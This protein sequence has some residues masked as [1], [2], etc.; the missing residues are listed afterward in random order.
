MSAA[1]G[2]LAAAALLISACGTSGARVTS[3]PIASI[4]GKPASFD[5]VEIDQG[6][7]RLYVADR[8]DQGVD[9]FD[10]SA[11]TAKFLKTIALKSSPN[12]LAIA[13]DLSR[14]Y[15]G[16]A[17]GSLA[18]VDINPVSP[19][20]YTVVQEVP[21]GGKSADLLDYGATRHEVYAG[22]GLDGTVTSIDAKTGTV[23]AH[24]TIGYAVEQPRFNPADG[25]LYVASPDADAMFQVNPNDG[26][27]KNKFGLGGCQPTGLAINPQSMVLIACRTSVLI[28]DLKTGNS[29]KFHQVT[30]GD[31]VTYSSKIGRFFV[32][33]PHKAGPGAVGMF[34]GSPLD[35]IS[36]VAIQTAGNSAAYDETNDV[37]Y[38]PDISAKNPGLASFGVSDS[39]AFV[40]PSLSS[41]ALFGALLAVIVLLFIAVGRS[42]DPAKRVPMTPDEAWVRQRR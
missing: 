39:G 25:L 23:K 28:W 16:M 35:F 14:L 33:S 20:G 30:G 27:I 22:N 21:T 36:A 5:V 18:V 34:G 1:L 13:P 32:A 15:A 10:I 9:V 24:F 42:A 29:V 8:T 31:V 2:L 17:N 37:V 3:T 26:K 19:T 4:A 6:S 41:L 40:A 12:G 38:T 11:P 7:H